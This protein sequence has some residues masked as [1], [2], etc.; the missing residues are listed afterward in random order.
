MSFGIIYKATNKING[1]IYIGQTVRG[2]R[3]RKRKH[4]NSANI[5]RDNYHFHNAL[6]KYK[7][8]DF[9]W[10]VICECNSREE[11][12]QKETYYISK[13]NSV[14]DGYNM[15]SS[16]EAQSGWK[17]KK[18]TK[19][20]LSEMTKIRHAKHG[21][22]NKGRVFSSKVRTR[23]SEA[24]KGKI[25]PKRQREEHSKLMTGAGNPMYG[26]DGESSPSSKVYEIVYPNGEVVVIKGLRKFCRENNLTISCM[27]ACSKDVQK[28]HKG[29]KCSLKG[30]L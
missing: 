6:R 14:K 2:L 28:Q 7:K 10:K 1:K 23:M 16:G 21:H 29:F 3:E 9:V 5:N 18:E 22:P 4:Y 8:I 13:F 15:R 30:V 26:K 20:K 25:I 17:H 27:Y 24:A 11:L 19:E 12:D